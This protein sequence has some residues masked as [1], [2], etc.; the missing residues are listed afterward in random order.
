[1]N[2]TLNKSL[3]NNNKNTNDGIPSMDGNFII[4]NINDDILG[5]TVI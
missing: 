1:M 3:C 4:L 2:V 5:K